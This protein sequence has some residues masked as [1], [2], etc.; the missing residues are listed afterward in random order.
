MIHVN[1]LLCPFYYTLIMS[2]YGCTKS[3][4]VNAIGPKTFRVLD[5]MGELDS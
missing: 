1:D 2:L 4:Q 3:K 5:L